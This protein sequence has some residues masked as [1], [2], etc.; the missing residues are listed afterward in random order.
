MSA[1]A[2]EFRVLPF[3]RSGPLC[4]WYPVLSKFLDSRRASGSGFLPHVWRSQWI[5]LCPPMVDWSLLSP[6]TRWSERLRFWQRCQHAQTNAYGHAQ[7]TAYGTHKND[8]ADAS[9]ELQSWRRH[10]L[11]PCHFGSATCHMQAFAVLGSSRFASDFS[12][13]D[14]LPTSLFLVLESLPCSRR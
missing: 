14:M 4:S 11:S 13:C 6:W 10:W 3:W 5:F 2:R 9:R 7:T 1:S 8:N 12:F